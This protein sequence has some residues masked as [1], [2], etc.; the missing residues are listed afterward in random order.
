MAVLQLVREHTNRSSFIAPIPNPDARPPE[1]FFNKGR[2]VHLAGTDDLLKIA[3]VLSTQDFKPIEFLIADFHFQ[4]IGGNL[5]D[6]LDE[7]LKALIANSKS[8]DQ[9]LP[10]AQDVIFPFLLQSVRLHD[11][12][13]GLNV[14][15]SQRGV[16]TMTGSGA[17][18]HLANALHKL[19]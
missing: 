7:R 1:W 19:P 18:D 8:L 2:D 15:V 6:Q 10:E 13:S 5:G 3:H 4:E 14:T 17:P 12:I 16:V 11:L 9:F